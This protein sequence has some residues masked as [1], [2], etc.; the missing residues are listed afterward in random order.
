GRRG[1]GEAR[2]ERIVRRGGP[3]GTIG[4]YLPASPP[5]CRRGVAAKRP[6]TAKSVD[7]RGPL[8]ATHRVA[9]VEALVAGAVAHRDVAAAVA[10]RR[11][12]HHFLELGVERA[13]ALGG[14]GRCVGGFG[15]QRLGRNGGRAGGGDGG[16]RARVCRNQLGLRWILD[17]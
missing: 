11:V 8:A 13:V 4:F 16:R 6:R 17:A 2:K 1:D 5:P 15:G 12:A 9:A 10:D 7:G 3:R 14:V